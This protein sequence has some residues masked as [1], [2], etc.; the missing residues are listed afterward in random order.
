MRSPLSW[1]CWWCLSIGVWNHVEA[2]L[3]AQSYLLLWFWASIERLKSCFSG[4]VRFSSS[5]Q[6]PECADL[7][8]CLFS[9]RHM[10]CWILIWMIIRQFLTS[11]QM[12]MS[13]RCHARHLKSLLASSNIARLW[14]DSESFD[15]VSRFFVQMID[16]LLGSCQHLY[17]FEHSGHTLITACFWTQEQHFW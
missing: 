14:S 4:L 16:R 5:T 15:I 10:G 6:S 7:W 1:A 13:W 17:Y 11:N 9:N 12:Q 8:R 3:M 2:L